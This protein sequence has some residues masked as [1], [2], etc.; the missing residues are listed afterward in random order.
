MS[1]ALPPRRRDQPL[2]DAPVVVVLNPR[3]GAGRAL[4]Q[5]DELKRAMDRVFSRWSLRVT[6]GPGHAGGLAAEA[7][8][9]GAAVVVA[10]GGDGTC[11]EV[12]VGLY[13]AAG[14]GRPS[15]DFA[16]LPF[17][18]G[19]DLQRSFRTPD[20]LMGALQLIAD[21]PSR[22]MDLGLAAVTR[23]GGPPMGHVEPFI[24]VAGFGANGEVVRRANLSDKRL[25]GALT[26]FGA[27]LQTALQYRPPTLRL[28]FG[29][30]RG[31]GELQTSLLSCFLAN[32]A[33]CGGGM[34]VGK[35][36]ALDDGLLDLTALPPDPALTQVL[37]SRRLY[38][39]ELDSWPGA[40]RGQVAWVEAEVVGDEPVYVDLDGESPGMLP[41]RFSIAPGA[42]TVRGRWRSARGTSDGQG[43]AP[44]ARI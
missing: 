15:A 23:P 8:A 17:G 6:E 22:P 36:G 42:L 40:R 33:Y 30:P 31:T 43:A 39:G 35:G 38:D 19:G 44:T 18:T 10:A 11:H 14:G 37:R 34:W 5:L 1:A 32:G 26:F 3:A 41:A 13:G 29:G 20:D 7:S 28:R 24:N 27:A 9:A 2:S 21:T 25:G 16:L 12:A 4:R